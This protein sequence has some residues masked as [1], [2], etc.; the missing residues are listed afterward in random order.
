MVVLPTESEK[1]IKSGPPAALLDANLSAVIF[2]CDPHALLWSQ[3]F[4]A[5]FSWQTNLLH[6]GITASVGNQKRL[7]VTACDLNKS[8]IVRADINRG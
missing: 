8:Y 2:L 3:Q 5:L 6:R 7:T 4:V 1:M